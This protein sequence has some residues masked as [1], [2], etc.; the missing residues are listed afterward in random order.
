MWKGHTTNLTPMTNEHIEEVLQQYINSARLAKLAGF[1]GIEILAQ[2]G[3]LLHNFLLTYISNP[4]QN[5]PLTSRSRSNQRTD[6]YGGSIPNRCR[7][8]VSV[9]DAIMEIW[10]AAAVGIKICPTDNMND[11]TSPYAEISETYTYLI[12]ELVKK[13]IGYINLS[14][15]GYGEGAVRPAGTELPPG[16]EPL[17]EFGPMIKFDDSKTKLLVNEGYTVAEAERLMEDGKIDMICFGRLFIFNPVSSIYGLLMRANGL[18]RISSG[19]W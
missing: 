12:G 5:D 2:G 15:R 3:Y 17:Q 4:I 1:D 6:M 14:R 19:A 9:V 8:V 7:F 18:L 11:T 13:E 16:Y 10:G